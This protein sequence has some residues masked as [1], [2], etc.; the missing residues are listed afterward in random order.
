[1][2]PLMPHNQKRRSQASDTHALGTILPQ[3]YKAHARDSWST[4]EVSKGSIPGLETKQEKR[5]KCAN[6]KSW[7]HN[8]GTT[9]YFSTMLQLRI[10]RGNICFLGEYIEDTFIQDYM[11]QKFFQNVYIHTN[12][13]FLT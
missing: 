7:L 9:L 6:C 2:T 5:E 3:K 10:N 12:L 8:I 13:D 11:H 1:M 4:W